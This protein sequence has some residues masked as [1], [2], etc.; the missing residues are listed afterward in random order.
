MNCKCSN[1]PCSLSQK[2]KPCSQ[3]LATSSFDKVDRWKDNKHFCSCMKRASL[4]C[5]KRAGRVRS[6][7]GK[8]FVG[9]GN[10]SYLR[11]VKIEAHTRTGLQLCA[12]GWLYGCLNNNCNKVRISFYKTSNFCCLNEIQLCKVF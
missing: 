4:M 11:F 2:Y 3:T 8:M 5:E 9:P 7:M 12:S 6:S 10:Q 1:P